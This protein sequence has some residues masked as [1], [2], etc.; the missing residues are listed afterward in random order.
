VQGL[1]RKEA[2]GTAKAARVSARREEEEQK[3]EEEEETTAPAQPAKR[4]VT[5]EL[6]PWREKKNLADRQGWPKDLEKNAKEGDR[7]LFAEMH[8]N[9]DQLRDKEKVARLQTQRALVSGDEARLKAALAAE[10][11]VTQALSEAAGYVWGLREKLD[12]KL[13]AVHKHVFE[14][15]KAVTRLYKTVEGWLGAARA[16]AFQLQVQDLEPVVEDAVT[17]KAA[18]MLAGH[19]LEE[20]VA[21]LN[22]DE[23]WEAALQPKRRRLASKGSSTGNG[24]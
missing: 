14:A 15:A 3:E 9:Y 19:R 18:S 22:D 11:R 10:E 1:R 7:T 5:L 6:A 16:G 13:G 2:K 24:W 21:L 4:N 12:S 17:A 23:A 8:K 20:A